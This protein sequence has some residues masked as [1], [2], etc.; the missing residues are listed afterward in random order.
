MTIE[1]LNLKTGC[2]LDTSGMDFD[3]D[4][5]KL[6]DD[7][8]NLTRFGE[9]GISGAAGFYVLFDYDGLEECT[10]FLQYDCEAVE[11]IKDKYKARAADRVAHPHK[12]NACESCSHTFK[13]EMFNGVWDVD[14]QEYLCE[15]CED[16]VT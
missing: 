16:I 7:V 12:T 11:A 4:D 14:Q 8:C 6:N 10:E 13:H 5:Q 15:N 3:I 2:M 9:T 1:M